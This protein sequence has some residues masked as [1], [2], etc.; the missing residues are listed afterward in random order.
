MSQKS[1]DKRLYF[2]A[3][4]LNRKLTDNANLA[5]EWYINNKAGKLDAEEALRQLNAWLPPRIA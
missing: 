5:N 1:T 2:V 4:A 3:Q